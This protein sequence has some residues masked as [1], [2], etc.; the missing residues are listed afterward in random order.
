MSLKFKPG[1]AID[2][3]HCTA[4]KHEF[5]CCED[6]FRE[7]EVYPTSMIMKATLRPRRVTS[8]ASFLGAMLVWRLGMRAVRGPFT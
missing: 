2:T 3:E 5:L 8:W 7:F 6:A 4:L 1:D